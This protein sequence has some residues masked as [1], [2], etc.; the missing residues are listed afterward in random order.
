MA[1][2]GLGYRHQVIAA[3]IRKRAAAGE[4]C[5]L[6][7]LPIDTRPP[8]KGGPPPRST[9]AFSAHHLTERANGGRTEI[10][11][12]APAHYGCNA[13]HGDGSA[14]RNRASKAWRPRRW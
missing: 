1:K 5:S 10:R 11:N 14:A 9:W 6:C 4:P 13:S 3:I 12:Y 7:G 8:S 2:E